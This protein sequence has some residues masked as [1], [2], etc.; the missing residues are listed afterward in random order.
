MF[1]T[2]QPTTEITLR[3]PASAESAGVARHALSSCGLRGELGHA[4]SLLV[5][6]VVGNAVRHGAAA[7]GSIDFHAEVEHRRL[8]IE[9]VDAGSGF[10]PEVRH[11]TPG[12][13]LRLLDQLATDW[14]VDRDRAGFR[15]WF[16]LDADAPRVPEPASARRGLR[17][18][19][20]PCATAGPSLQASDNDGPV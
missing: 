17:R 16:V 6:E 3:L 4:A 1:A 11:D 15:V 19:G 2:R 7:G 5:S 13:G 12:F 8:L 9:V 10:D 14:G 20:G 18:R